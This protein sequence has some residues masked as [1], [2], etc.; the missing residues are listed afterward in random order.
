MLSIGEG[1]TLPG[2]MPVS[3]VKR[4]ETPRRDLRSVDS[5]RRF[6]DIWLPCRFLPAFSSGDVPGRHWGC[7]IKK[8][9][10]IPRLILSS[11]CSS[12]TL[13]LIVMRTTKSHEVRIIERIATISERNDMVNRERTA[14]LALP[15]ESASL[16]VASSH[17]L[18]HL[19]PSR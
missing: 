1:K 9:S 11:I 10:V 13:D 18:A 16:T 4:I 19:L 14:T 7:K 6:A 15:F 12:F 5:S 17:T 3:S 8:T 2:A